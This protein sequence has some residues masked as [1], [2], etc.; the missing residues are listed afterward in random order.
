MT[1]NQNCSTMKNLNF[2]LF[3]S[4]FYVYYITPR[5]IIRYIGRK[6]NRIWELEKN[7]WT[8]MKYMTRTKKCDSLPSTFKVFNMK[9]GLF[10]YG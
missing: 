7:E 2:S 10:S 6:E 8:R 9:N 4:I 5:I 3:V 1:N